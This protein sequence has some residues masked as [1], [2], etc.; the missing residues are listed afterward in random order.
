MPLDKDIRRVGLARS[1]SKLGHCSRSRAV[2]LIRAGRVKLNGVARRSA[3]CPVRLDRD[4]IEVDDQVVRMREFVYVAMNKPRGLVTSASDEKGRKTIYALLEDTNQSWL[5]PVGR[6]DKASEGLLILTND[7]E[8]GHR[9]AAPESHLDKTYHVQIDRIANSQLIAALE[10]GIY[11]QGEFLRARRA[12]ILRSGAKNCWLQITL[13]EG[14][15]RH[16]RRM[17]KSQD[18]E[19]LRLVR[20]A[21]GPLELGT[22][23]KGATRPLSEE[24]KCA[25]D[26]ALRAASANRTPSLRGRRSKPA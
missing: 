5:A 10:Q 18:A 9:L 6:L 15:N 4:Q 16:I 11:D 26:E 23:A 22:L 1:L 19:V 24:E 7:S 8:W 2:E 13:D 21:I 20:V 14:R 25:L 3:E 17:L 12:H